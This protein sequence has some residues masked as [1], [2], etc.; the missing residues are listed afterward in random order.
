MYLTKVKYELIDYKE[1]INGNLPKA[2]SANLL[3]IYTQPPKAQSD[4]QIC[5]NQL[6]NQY[7]LIS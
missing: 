1:S 7:L 4:S 6:T 5:Y 3:Y 2:F